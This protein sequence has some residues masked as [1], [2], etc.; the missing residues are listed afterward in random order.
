MGR[1]RAEP[2]EPAVRRGR[3]LIG[4]PR[5]AEVGDQH[6][7]RSPV[8]FGDENI[9]G[10][11]IPMRQARAMQRVQPLGD[12]GD[13][14]H[15]PMQWQRF[16]TAPDQ[17]GE[18]GAVDVLHRDPQPAV[19]LATVAHRDQVGMAQPRRDRGLAQKS[20]TERRI[21]GVLVGQD[22]QRILAG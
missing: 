4:G 13:D 14:A 16:R 17:L 22:L 10:L 8:L 19:V 11:H 12:L 15:H 6:P 18:I 3:R 7:V 9:G 1:G 20:G 5:D 2:A 21:V